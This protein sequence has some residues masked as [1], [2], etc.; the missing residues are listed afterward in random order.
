MVNQSCKQHYI[1]GLLPILT[2]FRSEYEQAEVV[3]GPWRHILN[4]L[5]YQAKIDKVDELKIIT[6]IIRN[7]NPAGFS[8]CSG[9][10]IP[11]TAYGPYLSLIMSASSLVEALSLSDRYHP[12][13]FG[14]CQMTYQLN[15]N[16]IEIQFRLPI[17]DRDTKRFLVEREIAG[18][19]KF[20]ES[21]VH[22]AMQQSEIGFEREPFNPQEDRV[23]RAHFKGG[24][25]FNQSC[26][27]IRIPA[28]RHDEKLPNSHE[29]MF[30]YYLMQ[31]QERLAEL[32]F[33]A[34]SDV[35]KIKEI[36]K[37]YGNRLPSISEVATVMGISDRSL[38]RKLNLKNIT[39]RQLIENHRS[40]SAKS[41]LKLGGT[42][43]DE[44][45]QQLGYQSTSSFITAFKKWTGYT[46]GSYAEFFKKGKILG[47]GSNIVNSFTVERFGGVIVA[48]PRGVFD[49]RGVLSLRQAILEK[50]VEG[51][52]WVLV[53]SAK[54]KAALTP[55]GSDELY[56]SFKQYSD[57]GCLA[58]G[59]EITN[60]FGAVFHSPPYS[61][62]P[63][64]IYTS[65]IFDRVLAKA[66]SSLA[67]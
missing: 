1:S 31:C 7:H 9:F 35:D 32:Q 62:L 56:N 28:T 5:N 2:E 4:D 34:I 12:L 30:D 16:F 21:V 3:L 41:H 47:F 51:E 53:E 66:Q 67:K 18:F 36:I 10:N 43:I 42:S 49:V 38:R 37:G 54:D 14:F 55:E 63:I 57:S 58:I 48:H 50:T 22:A 6:E 46:P 45:S 27:W 26:N 61:D 17:S 29:I 59:L 65:E 25:N 19:Y 23:F 24:I 39:F 20:S 33:E 60:T 40:E 13:G 11:I 8:L 64:Q 52:P 44:L 15:E